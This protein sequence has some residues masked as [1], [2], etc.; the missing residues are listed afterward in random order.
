[1]N[2]LSEVSADTKF[3]KLLTAEMGGE[4]ASAFIGYRERR[5]G[6][7]NKNTGTRFRCR[8]IW[9]GAGCGGWLFGCA[10]HLYG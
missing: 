8:G 9:D 7:E 5:A 6:A 2:R 4:R 10:K 1:M 3:L